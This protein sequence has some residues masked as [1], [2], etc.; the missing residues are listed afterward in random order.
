[1][2]YTEG[3]ASYLWHGCDDSRGAPELKGLQRKQAS[4]LAKDFFNSIAVEFQAQH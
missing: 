3:V 2:W 1:M 4:S